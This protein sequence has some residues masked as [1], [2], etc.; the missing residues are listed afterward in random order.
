M[1][2]A[3]IARRTIGL[4]LDGVDRASTLVDL[5]VSSKRLVILLARVEDELA[6]QLSFDELAQ[7]GTVGELEALVDAGLVAR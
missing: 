5:G 6:E 7:V 3:D 4:E 1:T 2:F